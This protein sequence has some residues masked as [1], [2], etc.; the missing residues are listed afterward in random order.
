[1]HQNLN[2]KFSTFLFLLFLS[3]SLIN[4]ADNKS[5][6]DYIL[7]ER[8]LIPEGTAFDNRT[9][10]IYIGSTFKRKIIQITQDDQITDF[11][12]EKSDSV[13]ALWEWKW[14]KKGIYSGQTLLMQINLCLLSILSRLNPVEKI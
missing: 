4:C 7:T 11:I 13:L 12:T 6:Q 8:N 1:M 5:K 14:M 2:M 10:T 9:G 3:L